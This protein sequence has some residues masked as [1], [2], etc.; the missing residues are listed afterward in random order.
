MANINSDKLIVTN[1]VRSMQQFMEDQESF[2]QKKEEKLKKTQEELTKKMEAVETHKPDINPVS[3]KILSKKEGANSPRGL[4]L[5]TQQSI[6]DRKRE[7]RHKEY[8][9]KKYNTFHPQIS[10]HAKKTKRGFED[11]LADTK[12]KQMQKQQY[13][14][15]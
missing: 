4:G 3:K 8:L 14:I 7:Q 13:E 10:E 5:V 15:D 11:I 1:Q 9:S 2:Q 6:G 12:I